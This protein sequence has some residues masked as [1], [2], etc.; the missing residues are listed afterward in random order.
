MD[1]PVVS[2]AALVRSVSEETTTEDVAVFEESTEVDLPGVAPSA[3]RVS[4]SEDATRTDVD[5]CEESEID[6]DV[7]VVVPSAALVSI[8]EETI[9]ENV[10]VCEGCES[11]VDIPVAVSSAGLVSVSEET[12]D[13]SVADFDSPDTLE[14]MLFLLNPLNNWRILTRELCDHP[15][16]GSRT[17]VLKFEL[18]Q[19]AVQT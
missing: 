1:L 11:V 2:S 16:S 6:A 14:R 13:I 17:M 15:R 9:T 3:A 10:D 7:P 4:A 5:V 12:L 18:D 8:F 19:T